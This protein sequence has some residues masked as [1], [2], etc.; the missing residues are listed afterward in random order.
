MDD[1]DSPVFL[2]AGSIMREAVFVLILNEPLHQIESLWALL[3]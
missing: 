2:S 3:T 1:W